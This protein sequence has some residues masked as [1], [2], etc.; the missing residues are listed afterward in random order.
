MKTLCGGET[1]FWL[2]ASTVGGSKDVDDG[3]HGPSVN[4]V[5]VVVV[6]ALEE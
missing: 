1:V 6:R 3:L 5:F 4:V 2:S